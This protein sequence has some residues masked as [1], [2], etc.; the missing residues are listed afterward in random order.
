MNAN[1]SH[2]M[3]RTIFSLVFGAGL[4][5]LSTAD[6]AAHDVEY[7]PYHVQH[8]YAYAR[9]RFYPGWL[10]R[11]REFQRWYVHNQYRFKRHA[12]WHRRYDIYRFERR[13][14]GHGRRVYDRIYRDHDYRPYYPKPKK[15][16]H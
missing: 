4:V 3:K 11:N 14:R 8:H 5:L 15:H 9:E 16:S 1:I 2:I 13:H 7:R 12:S 10:R 6:A